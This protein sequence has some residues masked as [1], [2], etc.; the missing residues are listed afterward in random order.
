MDHHALRKTGQNVNRRTAGAQV[1]MHGRFQYDIVSVYPVCRRAHRADAGRRRCSAHRSPLH[2]TGTGCCRS[3]RS[4]QRRWQRHRRHRASPRRKPA[5]RADRDQRIFRRAA[6]KSGRGRHH[7][8]FADHPQHH[9]GKLARHQLDAHRVHP[10]RGPAGPGPRLR[11]G[12][13]H[14]P[15][16]R[17]PQPPAG[18]RARHLRSRADRGAARSAG[19]AVWPQH[20]RRC[21]KIR[22]QDAAAGIQPEAA[23]H[24]WHL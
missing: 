10:R 3:R 13:R 4:D 22:H 9:A 2:R 19:H 6:G 1:R 17:V 18:R 21:G 8:Y 15:R 11:S 14:L 23:R 12:R 5:G 16:R 7:R 24:L 20:H